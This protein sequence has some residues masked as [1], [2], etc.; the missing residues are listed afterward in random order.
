MWQKSSRKWCILLFP[1][2]WASAQAINYAPVDHGL[3]TE[4]HTA[5]AHDS[6]ARFA[7]LA[8]VRYTAPSA[9]TLGAPNAHGVRAFVD[10]EGYE[11]HFHGVNA[12]VK[13]PPWHPSVG[14]YDFETSLVNQDFLLLQ[15]MGVTVIRLGMMWAGVEPR[16][17]QYNYT[18]IETLR[19]IAKNAAAYGIYTLLDMHQDGMSEKFCGEGLPSWAVQPSGQLPFPEPVG[20][21]FRNTDPATGFPLRSECALHA[22]SSYYLSEA[23][24]TAYEALY[25][26]A[27]GLLDAWGAMWH[28]VAAVL[29][30]LAFL[31]QIYKY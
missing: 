5:Q 8:P 28:T 17:G 13:G 26:N 3:V 22:W 18:Y 7:G 24:S 30:L 14:E 4:D 29:N 20:P 9:I 21:A 25:S 1:Y 15:G 12:V 2:L 10:A 27:D 31:V 23:C 16:R 19:G 11:R 6:S